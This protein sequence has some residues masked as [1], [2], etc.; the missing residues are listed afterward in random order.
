M[1]Q[2]SNNRVCTV[3]I[4]EKNRNSDLFNEALLVPAKAV[5]F[6]ICSIDN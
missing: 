1:S 6:A 4:V 5:D 3:I 2:A